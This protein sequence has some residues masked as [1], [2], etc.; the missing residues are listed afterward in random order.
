MAIDCEKLIAHIKKMEGFRANP[1]KDTEGHLTVG[2][3]WNL[4][5]EPLPEGYAP[6]LSES[7]GDKLVRLKLGQKIEELSIV[8]N[9]DSAAEKRIVGLFNALDAERQSI[10][11][12][13][14]YQMG[15]VKIWNF[16][17]MW[18]ALERKDFNEAADEM[19]DSLAAQQTTNRWF[20][21]AARMRNT[22][23]P[24]PDMEKMPPNRPSHQQAYADR[25]RRPGDPPLRRPQETSG[26]AAAQA[27][28]ARLDALGALG[29]E[30]AKEDASM[31]FDPPPMP[32][33]RVEG[34]VLGD[35]EYADG[36]VELHAQARYERHRQYGITRTR[37]E[38]KE[39][40]QETRNRWIAAEH[41][42]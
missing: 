1:Y 29:A 38:W 10:I 18:N 3:G 5:A 25:I 21:H 30:A 34:N 6:P 39:L 13:C 19:L 37:K 11:V 33:E 15:T 36:P 26:T 8:R 2:Y 14:A 17:K 27:E 23:A 12:D 35:E 40:T 32:P 22:V 9:S 20:D 16:H 42:A 7:D 41:E 4:D 31:N 28:A 24:R